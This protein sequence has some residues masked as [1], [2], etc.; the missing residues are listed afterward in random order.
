MDALLSKDKTVVIR[1]L[2]TLRR[3]LGKLD[4][5]TYSSLC[6]RIA[7]SYCPLMDHVSYTVRYV[8][9][10]GFIIQL[11]PHL[12]Q[13][14]TSQNKS[15]EGNNFVQSHHFFSRDNDINQVSSVCFLVLSYT[16]RTWK[17]LSIRKENAGMASVLR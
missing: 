9:S 1:A 15:T 5:V 4:K 10:L 12:R 6:T 7:L 14:I 13:Y 11:E 2:M 8:R 16:M 17:S 3:L